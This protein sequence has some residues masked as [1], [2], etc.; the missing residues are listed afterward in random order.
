[1]IVFVDI[2]HASGRSAEHGEKLLAARTWIT[3]RLEDLSGLPC[4]LVR[5][6]RV[7][8]QL[9][10]R[11]D[12]RA[13]FLSGNSADPDVYDA[14]SLDPLYSTLREARRPVFGFCGGMQFLA[15]AFG[16][17]VVPLPRTGDE[18][19]FEFGYFPVEIT[20]H[21][22]VLDGVGDSPIVRHAHQLHVPE[23]PA[24]FRILGRTERTPVQIIADDD[25]RA[26]GTQFHPEYWTDEHPAGRTMIA[27]FLDWAGVRR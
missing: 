22:P 3:Y 14:A 26:F 9:L 20:D 13:I 2:E 12:V 5:Y 7:S 18:Q 27:N 16:S 17:P 21:H 11:L 19:A 15:D 25:R 10:D 6:D 23:P 8:N 1:M 24:G 4:M